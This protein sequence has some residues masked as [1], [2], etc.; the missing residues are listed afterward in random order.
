MNKISFFRKKK[1]LSQKLIETL[2]LL[3]EMCRLV[4]A[5]HEL[6]QL[7]SPIVENFRLIL[8]LGEVNDARWT[9]DFHFKCAIVDELSKNF[10]GFWSIEI[11][12]LSHSIDFDAGVVAG[13][14]SDVL[15]NEI[16][17]FYV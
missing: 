5:S 6:V 16:E 17:L 7:N 14:N 1:N 4:N 2:F 11:E 15:W 13:D 3:Y 10:F 8:L 9:I 12:K